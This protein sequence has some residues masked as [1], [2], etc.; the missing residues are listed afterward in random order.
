MWRSRTPVL[1]ILPLLALPCLGGCG[2]P[3]PAPTGV[4]ID[5]HR[6]LGEPVIV[7]NLTVWPVHTDQ[8]L[9]VGEFL[10]L[11]EA[12]GRGVAAVRE[13]GGSAPEGANDAPIPNGAEQEREIVVAPDE[14]LPQRPDPGGQTGQVRQLEQMLGGGGAVV[15]TLV[16]ENRGDLP[17]L[18]CAGTIVKGGQ[19][20]RQIGQDFVIAAKTTVP[21]DAFCVE[22][23]R[24]HVRDGDG[25]SGFGFTSAGQGMAI[26]GAR[27]SAQY[28]N[29]QGKV[30]AEVEKA[31]TGQ[32]IEGTTT[33]VAANEAVGV[34]VLA[35]REAMAKRVADH[36]AGL[37]RGASA[38]VG[39]A[40]AVDGKPVTV[41]AFAHERLLRGHLGAFVKAMCLEAEL[42]A[43][44]RG[45]GA[46]PPAAATAS[47]VV[48]LVKELRTAEAREQLT[49]AGNWNAYRTSD[50]G[51]NGECRIEGRGVGPDKVVLT[52]DWTAK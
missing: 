39:F 20:D 1:W 14:A 6:W 34:E 38:P 28:E 23:G 50:A 42:A 24:W 51:F 43:R 37:G 3:D 10:T 18:V 30:W 40:Y 8:P 26:K 25:I 16:I 36:F 7:G 5:D 2:A 4:R 47:D 29:D 11:E 46:G 41:R 45:E 15:N 48:A 27:A 13:V 35:Q 32:E 9:D 52:E 44:M 22:Q 33:L 12:E 31:L 21:V 49:A 19:Q 17:I